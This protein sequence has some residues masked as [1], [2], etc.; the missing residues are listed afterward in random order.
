MRR[1]AVSIVFP[2][3]A[4]SAACGANS[5][6]S[7]KA[8]S[9]QTPAQS[10]SAVPSKLVA[11][12]QKDGPNAP[13]I[14]FD[15]CL[16]ID[17]S[18]IEKAGFDPS[19][20]QRNDNTGD[21]STILGCDFFGREKNMTVSSINRTFE[22]ELKRNTPRL[23]PSSVNGRDAMIG[24]NKIDE[25]GC[26]VEMRT[27]FGVLVVDTSNTSISRPTGIKG[28]DGVQPIAE[29]IERTLPKGM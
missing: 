10:T 13:K 7:P 21:V 26:T 25:D 15:P 29:Q 11:P 4:L 9:S 6:D 17:D 14:T 8:D 16:Q 12:A 20:R 3:F 2:L 23:Q 22:F 5:G 28:C 18:T 27:K 24:L 1:A 19:T